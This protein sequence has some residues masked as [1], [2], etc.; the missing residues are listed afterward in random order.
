MPSDILRREAERLRHLSETC[1]Q[2]GDY[3]TARQL[4]KMVVEIEES[5]IA[6]E[7]EEMAADF[8][9]L[10]RL[11]ALLELNRDAQ[12]YLQRALDLRL[13]STKVNG[14]QTQ[15]TAEL[16]SKVS[17]AMGLPK[18]INGLETSR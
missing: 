15:E 4:L 6:A 10:G 12:I 17:A 2:Q 5:D 8:H 14:S 18:P 1:A 13:T 11:C 7:A 3:S 16:L 9:E